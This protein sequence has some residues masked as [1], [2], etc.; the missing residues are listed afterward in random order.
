V[1]D[2]LRTL[3]AQAGTVVVP[4]ALPGL[5]ELVATSYSPVVVVP[6]RDAADG[7]VALGTAPWTGDEVFELAFREAAQR[8]TSLIAVRTRDHALEQARDD[9]DLALSPW[10]VIHPGVRV[11]RLVVPDPTTALL[12]DLSTRAQLI[13]LGRSTRGAL[14]GLIV[15][16]PAVDLLGAAQCPVLVVPPRVRPTAG[17]GRPAWPAGLPREAEHT[18]GGR[19]HPRWAAWP[20]R[21]LLTV[22]DQRSS[23]G[24]GAGPQR[25]TSSVRVSRSSRRTSGNTRWWI[26]PGTLTSASTH[27]RL[28]A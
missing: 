6:E 22:R 10:T 13:V 20:E 28:R 24:R 15:G 25:A 5:P 27:H 26:D 8:R 21:G 16:S 7:P 3:S 9:L 18:P 1:V 11:E 14:L 17:G 12:L 2:R 23:A 19:A 4:A